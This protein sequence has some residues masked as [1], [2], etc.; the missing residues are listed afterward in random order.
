MEHIA[1]N[2]EIYSDHSDEEQLK[3]KVRG[4]FEN[5]VYEREI[6]IES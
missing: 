5:F 1:E 6:L 4:M 2:L 3:L